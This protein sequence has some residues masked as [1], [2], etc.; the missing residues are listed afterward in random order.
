MHTFTIVN[1]D[2]IT[3]MFCSKCGKSYKLATYGYGGGSK[4]W[5]Q[6]A[7]KDEDD[8]AIG[9]PSSDCAVAPTESETTK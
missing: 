9:M 3:I 7:F 6:L 2:D 1:V 8:K 5:K 4:A